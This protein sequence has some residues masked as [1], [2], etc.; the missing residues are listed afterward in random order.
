M[1]RTTLT[2][3]TRTIARFTPLMS[4]RLSSSEGATGSGFSRAGGQAAGD[5]FT[6]REKAAED[7]YFRQQEQLK[8]KELKIKLQK[9]RQH[10]DELD[11]HIDEMTKE[12][13]G[14]KN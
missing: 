12:Q 6:K 1:L 11:A 8:L 2:T 9:Q 14:E 7:M 10:L 13:G 4:T 5:S 3:S